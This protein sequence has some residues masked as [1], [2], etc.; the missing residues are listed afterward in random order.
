MKRSGVMRRCALSLVAVCI[1]ATAAAASE[2]V[3]EP[4][5]PR[6]RV[7]SSNVAA[8]GYDEP[9]RTL[10]VDFKSGGTYLYF[11]V[12]PGVFGEFLRAKSKGRFLAHEIK[13]RYAFRRIHRAAR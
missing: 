6:I 13:G 5:I 1:A 2:E 8:I 11:D 3:A 9:A 10:V 7:E 12:P 4:A